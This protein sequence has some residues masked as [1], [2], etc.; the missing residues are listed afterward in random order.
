VATLVA[1]GAPEQVF[2]AVT[3]E[4]ARLVPSM[5]RPWR[6]WSLTVRSSTLPA[7]ESRSTSFPLVAG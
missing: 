4:L 7:G 3:E 6:A 5:R 1:R 2:A